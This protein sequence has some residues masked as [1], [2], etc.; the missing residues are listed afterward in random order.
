MKNQQPKRGRGRPKSYPFDEHGLD[1]SPETI[2]KRLF[3]NAEKP[4][5]KRK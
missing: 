5:P 2:A 3:Q 1:A 4:K